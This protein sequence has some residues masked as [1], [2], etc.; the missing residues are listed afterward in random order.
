MTSVQ[1]SPTTSATR[2]LTSSPRSASTTPPRASSPR[3][4]REGTTVPS[5]SAIG[6]VTSEPATPIGVTLDGNATVA[7]IV[8]GTNIDYGT[9]TLAPGAHTLAGELQD[10]SGKRAPVPRPLHGVDA[11]R[12]RSRPPVDKN[13]TTGCGD[14]GGI[15]RRPG[16][17]DDARRAPGPRRPETGSFLRI[18]PMPAPDRTDERLRLRARDGRRDRALGAR[19]HGGAPVQPPDRR[20]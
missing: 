2:P 17:G 8:N 19:R 10:S 13:T 16:L 15:G 20:S 9:G 5:A 4:R 3:R 18:T 11:R 1:P 14:D 7:P 6:L 12:A